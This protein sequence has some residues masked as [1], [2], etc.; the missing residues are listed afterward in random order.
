MHLAGLVLLSLP[1]VAMAQDDVRHG[2]RRDAKAYPQGT[3]KEAL[4]SVLK[5]IE[6]RKFDYLVA[7][8][9]D[10]AFVDDRVKRIYGGKFAEQVEDTKARLDPATVKQ[11]R[12]FSSEGRWTIDKDSA[13]V[14]LEDV[15]ER[16]VRLVRRDGRWYLSHNSSPEK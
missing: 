7:Q 8:L 16:V 4:T 10:P 12:R 14:S 13:V 11:L 1:L 6:A 5:A 15:K 2:V 3:P 9:A